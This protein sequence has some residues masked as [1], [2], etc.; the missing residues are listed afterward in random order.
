MISGD[1]VELVISKSQGLFNGTYQTFYWRVPDVHEVWSSANQEQ[2]IEGRRLGRE[3]TSSPQ[4]LLFFPARQLY[5]LCASQFTLCHSTLSQ[6]LGQA[7]L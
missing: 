5:Y 2:I 1:G 6:H 3:G 4:S 7:G